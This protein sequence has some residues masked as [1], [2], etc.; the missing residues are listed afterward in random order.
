MPRTRSN[1]WIADNCALVIIHLDALMIDLKAQIGCCKQELQSG[2]CEPPYGFQHG[3]DLQEA[4]RYLKL[5]LDV[6]RHLKYHLFHCNSEDSESDNEEVYHEEV[7]D[8]EMVEAEGDEEKGDNEEESDEE[9]HDAKMDEE[10]HNDTSGNYK[11]TDEE[12]SDE[13]ESDEEESDEE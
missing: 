6:Y 3:F 13:E 9:M 12:E 2:R 10:I 11:P 4:I 7:E 1:P 5:E 8:D